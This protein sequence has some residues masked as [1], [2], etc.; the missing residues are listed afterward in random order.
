MG[1]SRARPFR[2]YVYLGDVGR[3]EGIGGRRRNSSWEE[4]GEIHL[5][6]KT[7]LCLFFLFRWW[8]GLWPLL[9]TF[10]CICCT[11]WIL[12]PTPSQF[13]WKKNQMRSGKLYSREWKGK[14]YPRSS[15]DFDSCDVYNTAG[16]H[17]DLHVHGFSLSWASC[18]ASCASQCQFC[19]GLV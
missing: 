15:L 1:Y 3:R 10:C 8:W 13:E 4:G 9:L 19:E 18:P 5:K 11:F 6:K 12:V 16:R 14:K 7:Q 2:G 17:A